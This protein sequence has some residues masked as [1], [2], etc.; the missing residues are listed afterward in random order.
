MPLEGA[1]VPSQGVRCGGR[2]RAGSTVP[3]NDTH[4]PAQYLH[5]T[6][7]GRV[8]AGCSNSAR[9]GFP[10]CVSKSAW[11]GYAFDPGARGG[12]ERLMLRS[13]EVGHHGLRGPRARRRLARGTEALER[14]R[15]SPEGPGPSNE[16]GSF[17]DAVSL[18]SSETG[19]ARG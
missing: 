15:N 12:P 16:A 1:A 17:C 3:R 6:G 18:P 5:N 2:I 10:S 7:D 4:H 9:A 8:M 11:R 19:C 14:G 13:G